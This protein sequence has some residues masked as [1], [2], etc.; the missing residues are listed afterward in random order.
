MRHWQR[1]T[2]LTVGYSVL[3]STAL[4][5]QSARVIYEQDDKLPIRDHRVSLALERWGCR[6]QQLHARSDRTSILAERGVWHD[7]CRSACACRTSR[8]AIDSGGSHWSQA[9]AS[10]HRDLPSTTFQATAPTAWDLAGR[11]ARCCLALGSV[12]GIS[13]ACV[14]RQ[15][16]RFS[17]ALPRR[18]PMWSC[19]TR[20]RPP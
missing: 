17:Q 1:W 3:I 10:G 16:V 4:Y 2:W 14:R 8:A 9:T 5:G 19:G 7:G 15:T 11:R 12:R 20:P 18:A 13:S 6:E